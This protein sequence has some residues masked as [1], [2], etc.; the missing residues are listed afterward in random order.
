MISVLIAKKNWKN[1]LLRTEQFAAFFSEFF[2]FFFFYDIILMNPVCSSHA[3]S[4]LLIFMPAKSC[5]FCFTPSFVLS[6]GAFETQV[7]SLMEFVDL[8]TNKEVNSSVIHLPDNVFLTV[9][10]VSV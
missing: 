7:F 2:K 8:I 5:S 10:N 4:W 9:I 3:G 6:V 1:S